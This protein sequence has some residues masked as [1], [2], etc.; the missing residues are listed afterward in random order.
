MIRKATI[1]PRPDIPRIAALP[2]MKGNPVEI[3]FQSP[4]TLLVGENGCGKTTILEAIAARCGIRPNGGGSYEEWEDERDETAISQA[5]S[6]DTGFSRPRGLFMRADK[7]SIMAADIS[8]RRG[9]YRMSHSDEWRRLD[10]QSRGEGMLSLL[11]SHLE[12]SNGSLYVL[13][14]PESA[15]SPMRQLSLLVM[16][17]E[18]ARD[19]RSQAII[20]THSPI[21]MA[22]PEADILWVS[23]E[24][25]ERRPVEEV[26]HFRLMSRFM[27]DPQSYVRKLLQD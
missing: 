24:G 2:F 15:L 10:E 1:H 5:V 13:D 19:G 21:L 27:R 7:L 25:I 8:D 11:G 6:V 16:L 22:H 9:T 18:I 14:E 20:A 17:D 26:D 3:E 12:A 4:L 23:E